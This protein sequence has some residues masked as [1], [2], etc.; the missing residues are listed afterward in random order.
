MTLL[1]KTIRGAL[2]IY[3]KKRFIKAIGKEKIRLPIALYQYCSL[4]KS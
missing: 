2:K 4:F 3:I 1:F